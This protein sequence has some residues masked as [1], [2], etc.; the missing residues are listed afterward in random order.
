MLA[1]ALCAHYLA[2]PVLWGAAAV[3]LLGWVFVLSFFRNPSRTPPAGEHQ[4]VSPAD[5]TVISVERVDDE[6]F[7]GGPATRISIF[8]SVFNCHVNRAPVAGVVE[9]VHHRKGTFK[10]AM[11]AEA[12][13]SNECQFLGLRMADGTPVLVRQIAGLIARRIVCPVTVGTALPRGYDYGMIRFGSQ[14][15][16]S[17]PDRDGAVFEVRV[18]PGDKVVGGVTV[19]GMWNRE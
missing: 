14:T 19:V 17:V 12:R 7:I 18:G 2:L 4:V 5:G 16:V 6:D 15:E 10:N 8:L 11:K 1:A 13:D 3:F 9:Y